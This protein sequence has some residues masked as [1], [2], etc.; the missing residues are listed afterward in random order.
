MPL[1]ICMKHD[2]MHKLNSEASE[3]FG[4][5]RADFSEPQLRQ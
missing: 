3:A 1:C 2:N 5:Q 4:C